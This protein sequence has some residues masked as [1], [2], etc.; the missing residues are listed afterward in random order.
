MLNLLKTSIKKLNEFKEFEDYKKENPDA[1]FTAGFV[2]M[3][4]NDKG[5]WQIDFY[6]PKKHKITSF[7]IDKKVQVMPSEQ[8]FQKE[9]KKIEKLDIDKVKVTLNVAFDKI[10]EIL[11]KKFPHEVPS[12]KIVIIQMLDG[13][14]IWNISYITTTFNLINVKIDAKN[15][16]VLEAKL[17]TLL[18]L[19]KK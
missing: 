10:N 18:D 19:R 11:Q 12:K 14:E 9:V 17:D 7:V 16:K 6:S 1:Y 5:K 8:I 3:D 15:G 2:M 4:E 13:K